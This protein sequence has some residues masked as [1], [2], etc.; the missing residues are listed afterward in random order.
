MGNPPGSLR[1]KVNVVARSKVATFWGEE[2]SRCIED[3]RRDVHRLILRMS[4]RSRSKVIGTRR[5]LQYIEHDI[6]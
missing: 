3:D 2:A 4:S 5:C 6:R 1:F